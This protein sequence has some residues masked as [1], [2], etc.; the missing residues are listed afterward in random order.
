MLDEGINMLTE[1]QNPTLVGSRA[2]DQNFNK[3]RKNV[4]KKLRSDENQMT[5][6][7]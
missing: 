2:P 3:I 6:Y 7:Q 4:Y 1:N 5:T